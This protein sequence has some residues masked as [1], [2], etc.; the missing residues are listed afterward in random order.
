MK[1][2]LAV[3]V[4]SIY[5]A[6]SVGLS[7][8]VHQCNETN[9]KVND[10]VINP[11]PPSNDPCQEASEHA[12]CS[13]K[14]EMSCCAMEETNDDCCVDATI[15]IHLDD[16]QIV[17]KSLSLSFIAINTNHQDFNLELTNKDEVKAIAN[18]THPPPIEADRPIRF[19]SLTFYG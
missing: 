8:R 14:K 13:S 2:L 16:E 15:L 10:L 12:C 17:S 18:Y 19:C 11:L 7:L 9:A 6:L 5:F 3:A 1:S 4:A